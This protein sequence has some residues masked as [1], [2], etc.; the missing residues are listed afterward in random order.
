MARVVSTRTGCALRFPSCGITLAVKL[1]ETKGNQMWGFLDQLKERLAWTHGKN[2]YQLG[3]HDVPDIPGV[4]FLYSVSQAFPY[5]LGESKIFY[6]GGSLTLRT[7]LTH[8][9]S[10]I[11]ELHKNSNLRLRPRYEYAAAFGVRYNYIIARGTR[12]YHEDL[13][14]QLLRLFAERYAVTPVA[15][16]DHMP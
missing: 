7:R 6:I 15:N 12:L 16:G 13:E 9:L 8:H 5:P 10:Q 4:Y 3:N 14:K 11:N 2:L 1:V